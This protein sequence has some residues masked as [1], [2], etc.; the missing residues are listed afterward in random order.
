[1]DSERRVALITGASRGLGAAIALRLARDGCDVALNFVADDARDN[2]AEAEAVAEQARK[3]DVE[4][5]CVEADVTDRA[6]VE[7]MVAEVGE[8]LGPVDVLVNNAGIT[9]DR[10]LRKLAPE[11]WDSVLA[12]NL[13]GA[14][15]CCRAVVEGMTDRGWGRIV[16]VSSVVA[17]LGNFG[18]T[19]YAASKAGLI[20]LTRSLAR[21]VARKG[22]TVNAVAP[23]FIRTEMTAA[24]PPEV[25]EQIVATIPIGAMG[26]AIDVA[27]A[28]AFLASDEARYITGHVLSVNGG[29]C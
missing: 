21:E 12:V 4:A 25:V 1:M 3:L 27:N 28:V 20:G 8:R 16:S 22:V 5:L 26:E 9:R 23:G 2:A 6:A 13:T 19:N 29:M 11:D 7:A 18:Q 17:L 15:N 24:I 10:T 14:F